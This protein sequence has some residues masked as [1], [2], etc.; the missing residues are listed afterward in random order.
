MTKYNYKRGHID[1][2]WDDSFKMLDYK[3]IPI[4]NTHDE[5]RWVKEGYQNVK[6]NGALY[7]MSNI[8]PDYTTPFFTLFDWDNVGLVFFRMNT[9]EMF[10]K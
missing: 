4:K 5:E 10:I 2:W 7:N 9:L 6:L 3:Y 8:M 1:P